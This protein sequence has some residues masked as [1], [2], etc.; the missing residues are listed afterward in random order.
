[1]DPLSAT[2]S[3]IAILQLSAKVLEY[4]NDV[5]D[6][7]KDRAQCTIEVS[8][9]QTLLF[10]LQLWYTAVQALAVENGP[11][12]QFK[13]ALVTLQTKMTE[14]GRL[15]KAGEALIWKFKK[16]EIAS[17]L[18]RIERLKLLIEIALQMDH[19]KL[20]QAIKDDTNIIRTHVSA[21]QTGIKRIQQD[22]DYARH[23]RLLEWLSP[24]DYP[25]QQSDIIERRQ[26]G[27]GQWFLDAPE[28]A[29]WLSE[30]KGTL[31]CPG[32]PGAGKTMV[33]AIAIDHLLRSVQNSL[34]GV[35]YVYC[36]Y[37][38]Q[39]E[40]DAC[41]MLAAILKQ[42]VQARPSIVKP[43][44]QLHQ[45]HADR[46]T[47]PSRDEIFGALRDVL[48]HCPTVYIVIDALDE[49]R[50]SDG[51]R[52]QLLANLRDLQAGEDVRLMATSRL[53]P[54]IVD[55]F[56]EALWLEVQASK[57]DVKRFVAGQVNRLPLCIQR[58]PLLQDMVQD[59]IVEA[60][61]GMYASCSAL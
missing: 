29:R 51:T 34:H 33:A 5:K 61:D 56:G 18:A 49:C 1:M 27:T 32:I 41:S 17:I 6:A 12:D 35:A 22:Q 45:Q 2:A 39:K 44:E 52:R 40:Q 8:N 47:R 4:L 42:L 16:E 26:E 38:A 54:E 21:I 36:N 28:V 50:S 10:S 13:Q 11:L 59:K 24:T 23:R 7:S 19:F 37:K 25:A 31:F 30:A 15:K 43:I 48:A 53:M 60:V 3:I 46:G 20:S 57:E 55:G 58:N 9:L 14:G